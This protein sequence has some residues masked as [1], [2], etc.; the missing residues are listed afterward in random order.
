M[1]ANFITGLYI[2]ISINCLTTLY[3]LFLREKLIDNAIELGWPYLYYQQFRLRGSTTENHG[4]NIENFFKNQFLYLL[5]AF[6]I[7][8]LIRIWQQHRKQMLL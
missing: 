2:S 1:K 8:Y 7:I 5:A 4:W 3:S 6:L